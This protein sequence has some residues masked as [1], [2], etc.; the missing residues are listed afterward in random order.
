MSREVIAGLVLLVLGVVALVLNPFGDSEVQTARPCTCGHVGEAHEHYRAGTDCAFC[1]CRRYRPGPPRQAGRVEVLDLA[2]V[3]DDD[4]FLDD[5]GRAS[6]P[7][8]RALA[9]VLRE[10]RDEVDQE[11]GEAVDRLIAETRPPA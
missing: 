5:L 1:D 8:D 2:Q 11:I 6:N 10:A 9:A 7:A 4:A 3:L